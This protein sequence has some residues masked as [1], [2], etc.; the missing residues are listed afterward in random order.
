M[1]IGKWC[2]SNSNNTLL[3]LI[4]QHS[5]QPLLINVSKPYWM[6]YCKFWFWPHPMAANV[7]KNTSW[8]WKD[9]YERS[10][11]YDKNQRRKN[12]C[13]MLPQL[14]WWRMNSPQEKKCVFLNWDTQC[15]SQQKCKQDGSYCLV[16]VV[17]QCAF[18][19]AFALVLRDADNKSSAATT[20]N[21][22]PKKTG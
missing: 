21:L 11:T 8:K 13:L 3:F 7:G 9:V 17:Y 20:T 1:E 10:Q 4:H 19:F 18:A 16:C 12:V 15:I 2:N 6:K 14:Q 22:L 5:S